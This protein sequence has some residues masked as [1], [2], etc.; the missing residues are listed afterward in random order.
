MFLGTGKSALNNY[1]LVR[2]PKEKYV[3]ER[4]KISIEV[5]LI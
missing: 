2:L 4:N 1:F 5:F 3:N